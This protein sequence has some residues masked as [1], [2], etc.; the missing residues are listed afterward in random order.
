MTDRASL[1]F[2]SHRE[3]GAA[4]GSLHDGADRPHLDVAPDDLAESHAS[5]QDAHLVADAFLHCDVDVV[6][7]QARQVGYFRRLRQHCQSL[8]HSNTHSLD[9]PV[10]GRVAADHTRRLSGQNRHQL[11]ALSSGNVTRLRP[12]KDGVPACV[13]H[14]ALFRIETASP[15]CAGARPVRSRVLRGGAS[16]PLPNRARCRRCGQGER[17][18][19]DFLENFAGAIFR[20]SAASASNCSAIIRQA[21]P[22]RS[23]SQESQT[24][25]R[26]KAQSEWRT[27][28]SPAR[29]RLPTKRSWLCWMNC[30][31]A[32]G[33]EE[34]CCG[35]LALSRA[36]KHSP[37][38][39]SD[40]HGDH[41]SRGYAAG[42]AAQLG[43]E[44]NRLSRRPDRNEG[45]W[46]AGGVT[47]GETALISWTSSREKRWS[48]ASGEFPG[49]DPETSTSPG[50]RMGGVAR[51]R[52][53]TGR[54]DVHPIPAAGYAALERGPRNP[55]S[56]MISSG[57][58]LALSR[59]DESHRAPA[60]G[61][62]LGRSAAR[63]APRE[64]IRLDDRRAA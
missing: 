25:R 9:S 24:K 22:S 41:N 46:T 56:L 47:A 29:P 1:T 15:R 17:E 63:S 19:I 59:G 38:G 43:C 49:T 52:D 35:A 55:R 3:L 16:C 64:A 58:G 14:R 5:M 54:R 30:G 2:W 20:L 62:Y 13:V 12:E 7:R 4:V 28:T 8:L 48:D 37:M 11:F 61:T 53:V 27:S 33:L 21:S 6:D 45:P 31:P 18:E 57:G 50:C 10:R 36:T 44:G 32:S 60:R 51:N 42:N 26:P 23:A 40:Y 34:Y 39:I